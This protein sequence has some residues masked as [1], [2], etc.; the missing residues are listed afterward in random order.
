MDL[1]LRFR[2][3]PDDDTASEAWRHI[4][5]HRQ[6]RNHAVRDYYRAPRND[7]P[8]AYD[9]HRKLTEWKRK[10]SM[11]KDVSAHAAQQTVSQIHKDLKVLKEHRKNGRKT[12]QLKWQGEGEVR[13]V[14]YQ[15]EGFNV[16]HTTD[17]DDFGT[18]TLSK[19]GEIP[20]RAHRDL[21]ATETVKR[22]ILKKERTGE[23]FACLVIEVETPDKPNP[24]EID[25]ADCVGVDLGIQ[26]YIHTSDDLSVECLDL[27]G[28]YDHYAKEQRSL[29]RKQRG[30]AN[31]ENQR[32]KVAKAKRRIRWKVLDFQHKL[33]TWLVREYDV[34]AVE[35][36]DVKPMLET[37]QSA[38]NKQDAAWSRFLDLLEYKGELHGT[39][40]VRVDARGTTKE[41]NECGVET[42]KPLWVRE[43]SCPACGHTE[44]RDL[45]AA[46]NILDRGLNKLSLHVGPG[47]SESTPVQTVLPAFTRHSGRVDAKHVV[48]AGSP[49]A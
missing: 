42:S 30:S 8:S 49:A 6:I 33:S 45:N 21:P 28:E 3:Y 14:A 2:A 34:V 48:E 13:S 38:K 35:D 7:R 23:W 47:R 16:N 11:F 29:D 9:Q 39:H 27:S 46:K 17:H 43:H 22:A 36:L 24:D 5:I 32:R 1:T 4:N 25:P 40:V 31:W 10:W 37:S 12:G 20:I 44:D 41:C 26:S 18:L 19:I 15:S